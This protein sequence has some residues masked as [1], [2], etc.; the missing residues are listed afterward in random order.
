[1][2]SP[3]PGALPPDAWL[4]ALAALPGLGPIR[5]QKLLADDE[6]GQVWHAVAAGTREVLDRIGASAVAS[7]LPAA[8]R[9]IDVEA[10]WRRYRSLGIGVL[11]IDASAFPEALRCDPE[12]PAVLFTRGDPSC[13]EDLR[14]GV[15]GTRQCTRYGIDLA[16]DLG[17]LCA[18]AGAT[19]VSGL[20]A[21]IDAA[22]HHGALEASGG[23]PVGVAGTAL[24]SPYPRENRRL[25]EQVVDAGLVCGET[26]LD[27]PAE[28]WRFPARN[29]IIAALSHVVVVIE[30]HERGGSLYT[31]AQAMDRGRTVFAVPGP[32][33][34]PAS[35]GCNRLLAD[36]CLPLCELTDVLVALGLSVATAS[37]PPPVP[38][39]G[40]DLVVLDAVGWQAST[41][42]DVL[43]RT[44]LVM[45]ELA[46]GVERLL[47]HGL[48]ERRGP[49]LERTGRS[50]QL[51]RGARAPSR[52]EDPRAPHPLS[53]WPRGT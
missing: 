8:A 2:T 46:L 16:R 13:I 33:Q 30:S 14:V 20:A 37:S 40:V 29:R 17:A 18:Q 28:R 26:P 25:W 42:S 10:L 5:L 4:A 47:A 7:G 52:P 11:G 1:M 39:D 19:V 51:T 12:P 31:A 27:A 34:S 53:T 45:D 6:P 15:V 21:G 49:W 3:G 48:L 43:A 36:G 35:V 9:A 50:A 23:A 22:A 32:I 24:D 44:G 41:T 38:V